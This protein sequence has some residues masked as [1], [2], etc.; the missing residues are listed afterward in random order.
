MTV[1]EA[2]D[3]LE[4]CFETL[5]CA[6]DERYSFALETERENGE[7]KGILKSIIKNDGKMT[8]MQISAV[9]KYFGWEIEQ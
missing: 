5:T 9:N 7:L 4:R 2:W 1:D 6:R 3:E 8:P